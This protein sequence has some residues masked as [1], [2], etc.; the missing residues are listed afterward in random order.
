MKA[1]EKRKKKPNELVA[2][3]KSFTA[4]SEGSIDHSTNKGLVQYL[5]TRMDKVDM[6]GSGAQLAYFFL[7]SFFP[8]LIFL[9]TLLP[10]LNLRQYQVFELMDDIMPPEVLTM[11]QTV[12][13]ETL[14]VQNG[15]LLSIGVLGTLWSA[16]RGVDALMRS[17]NRA[18]DV[19][20]K[21]GFINRLWALLFTIGFVVVIL[22]ALLLPVFGQQI[23]NLITTYIAVDFQIGRFWVFFKWIMPPS[24]IFLLI[25]FIYWIVPNTDPSLKLM[26]VWP[27][28]IFSTSGW[29]VLTYGFSFYVNNFGNYSATYGSIG[30]VIILML[31]LYFTGMLLIFGGIINAAV[32]KRQQA[33]ASKEDGKRL[34]IE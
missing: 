32:L 33:I 18:Y 26:S 20:G 1:L 24:L 14:T 11:A 13:G 4:I 29:L 5:I 16:S 2:F 31:W 10:Y 28:A 22:V 9:V 25:L 15:S 12:L 6:S 34:T 8:L 27:G 3:V 19:D 23:F 7:L 21:K 17:L 30:G